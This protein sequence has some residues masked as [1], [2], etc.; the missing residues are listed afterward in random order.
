MMQKFR[1][2]SLESQLFFSFMAVSVCLLL[3]S[4][5]ITLFSTITRQRQ[6]IDKN[7]SALAA[8]VASM[9]NVVSMLE[10]GY[11]DGSANE[12]LDSLSENF[13]DLNVMAIYNT[14][15]LRFYHTNRKE[16]GE[17]FVGGD[18]K[19]QPALYHHRL[20]YKRFPAAGFPFD[21]EQRRSDHRIR[22]SVGL[23]HLYLRADP[24]GL[25]Y[26]F[27][28]SD[29]HAAR[30]H[31]SV[32]RTRLPSPGFPDGTSSDGASRPVSASGYRSECTGGGACRHGF[33]R[34]RGLR[35]SGG[36]KS[37]SCPA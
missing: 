20:R 6:E 24:R 35:K 8:Y 11:P 16:T 17:T 10:N 7:I 5:S 13:P 19:G 3:L 2:L 18:L 28:S 37:L 33:H 29:G 30:Q 27:I 14:T 34:F 22:Y 21:P 36:R 26:L 23:Q 4:L 1:K 9:D 31:P 25:S 12:E 15:G 32:S